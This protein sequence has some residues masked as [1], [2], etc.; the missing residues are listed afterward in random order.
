M[1]LVERHGDGVPWRAKDI[2]DIRETGE[3]CTSHKGNH[4]D[5]AQG[6]KFGGAWTAETATTL[7]LVFDNAY[8]LVVP[9]VDS[10]EGDE[11]AQRDKKY[12]S[13]SSHRWR[14]GARITH[15]PGVDGMKGDNNKKRTGDG[16]GRRRRRLGPVGDVPPGRGVALGHGGVPEGVA[17]APYRLA[18]V[19]YDCL[20]F[21]FL[22]AGALRA[23][24]FVVSFGESITTRG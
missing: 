15:K 18:G 12:E 3:S 21:D 4:T 7:L 1:M 6:S 19:I 13:V 14:G 23:F 10:V 22:S 11:D 20:F 17:R 8:S 5:N 9:R 24:F 16:Q 2:R